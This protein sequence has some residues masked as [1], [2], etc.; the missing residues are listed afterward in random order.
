MK[1]LLS[2][3]LTLIFFTALLCGC[4]EKYD[5]NVAIAIIGG[6]HGNSANFDIP[7]IEFEN[8]DD[9]NTFLSENDC[10]KSLFGVVADNNPNENYSE[11]SA[12]FFED[13]QTEIKSRRWDTIQSD[14]IDFI[15]YF[16]KQTADDEEVDTLSAFYNVANVFNQQSGNFHKRILVFDSGLC[17]DGALNFI[18]NTY[19]KSLIAKS[20]ELTDEEVK[21]VVD[22]LSNKKE[23]PHLPNTQIRWYGIGMTGGKQTELTKIQISNLTAIWKGILDAAGAEVDFINVNSNNVESNDESLPN[24]S[25][26]MF[27]AALSLGEDELG[28]EP[29]KANFREGTE[30]KR[31]VVLEK[32]VDEAK[33]S[34]VLLVGTTSSGGATIEDPEDYTLSKDRA[35]AVKEELIKL[36]VPENNI[37]TMGLG[38]KSH[39]YNPN[40][41]VEGEYIDDSTAAIV[42]RSVYIMSINSSEAKEFLSDYDKLISD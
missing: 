12:E 15:N 5:R 6:K 4:N 35:K 27:D 23:I 19:Y 11:I 16:T 10:V 40:E 25:V 31:N 41:F 13:Y 32:F 1:K 29:G 36:G 28:F 39:K 34:G 26:V 3:V 17:T 20:E 33:I 30:E 8:S 9:E 2:I 14:V 18:E 22:E 7:T 42:N 37:E 21:S 24:V 38:T